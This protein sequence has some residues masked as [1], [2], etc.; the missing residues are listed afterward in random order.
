LHMVPIA[1]GQAAPLRANVWYGVRLEPEALRPAPPET[2]SPGT[3]A[4]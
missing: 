1:F 3:T 4:W 2:P